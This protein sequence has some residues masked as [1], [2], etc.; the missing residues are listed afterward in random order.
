[1]ADA[2]IA[3]PGGLG[4]IEEILE[5]MTWAQLGLHRKP[6]G[7]LNIDG[8]YDGLCAFLDHAV[9]EQFLKAVHRTYLVIETDPDA[10]LRR[11]EA[12]EE[13]RGRERITRTE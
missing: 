1:L 9:E 11:L 13:G 7:L 12:H 8:Y 5:I 4:T 10:L 2:F 6:C 3:M